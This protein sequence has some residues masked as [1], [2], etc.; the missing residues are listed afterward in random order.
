[1][2]S[3]L[4]DLRGSL[5]SILDSSKPKF[6]YLKN[7]SVLS[8]NQ[9]A[10]SSFKGVGKVDPLIKYKLAKQL[11]SR[12][13][14][15]SSPT[16]DLLSEVL[17][18]SVD[19]NHDNTLFLS[20]AKLEEVLNNFS[21]RIKLGEDLQINW[22]HLF[23]AY[24]E[25]SIGPNDQSLFVQQLETLRIFLISTWPDI[26]KNARQILFELKDVDKYIS[27]LEPNTCDAYSQIWLDGLSQRVIQMTK[28]LEIPQES[29]FWENLF[30]KVLQ[31][32]VN[33]DDDLFKKSITNILLLLDTCAI[34][35]DLGI[36]LTLQRFSKCTST[37][38]HPQLKDY[39]Y[40]VWGSPLG[41]KHKSSTWTTLDD[42]AL[43]IAKSWHHETNLRIFYALKTGDKSNALQRLAF[44]LDYI[45]QIE[46]S[47]LALGPVAQKIIQ[48]QSSLQRIFHPLMNPFAKLSGDINP[49]QNAIIFKI[50]N[51]I[52]IDFII[53]D[54]CYIYP[55]GSNTFD[56]SQ[57]TQYST[58][59]KGGLKERYGKFGVSISENQ[60]WSDVSNL[61]DI[62]N[63]YDL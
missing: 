28:D 57:E 48:T 9:T 60:D 44:W 4:D 22:L 51:T 33:F 55:P 45:N 16:F 56:V 12:Q 17:H 46:F 39:I 50:K 36:Q 2:S 1:M 26:K 8:A 14:D 6:F 32:I 31:T 37:L 21:N 49:E 63:K 58:S 62:L 47:K 24:L 3:I 41:I 27:I 11:D 52:I 61:K 42:H 18:V 34:H 23:H 15:A 35:K 5:S 10:I 54:G 25:A 43:N 7:S 30:V 20:K 59:Y 19:G 38:M 40:Q 13:I 53:N 29:W